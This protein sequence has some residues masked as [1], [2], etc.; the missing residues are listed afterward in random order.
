MITEWAVGSEV[1]VVLSPGFSDAPC[2]LDAPEPVF[3]QAFVSE[4]A[5]EA[6][7]G[8]VLHGLSGLDEVVPDPA[9]I[10]PLVEDP[11]GELRPVVGDD[12]LRSAPLVDDP[13]QHPPHP[14]TRQAGVH[15]GG[16]ALP[17]E[18]I[19]HVKSPQRPAIGQGGGSE[20]HGPLLTRSSGGLEILPGAPLQPFSDA[21]PHRQPFLLVEPVDPF[22]VH[23]EALPPQE[24]GAAGSRTASARQ[25]VPAGAGATRPSLSSGTDTDSCTAAFRAPDRPS[26]RSYETGSEGPPRPS[27]DPGASEFFCEQVPQPL[28]VEREFPHQLL[29]LSVLLLEP[30]QPLC[31]GHI[32]SAELGLPPVEGLL[33]HA[34][35]PADLY[36]RS[37]SLVLLQGQ[38]DL[39]L[40]KSALSQGVL[41]KERTHIIL[42]LVFRE[43]VMG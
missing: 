34:K 31:V 24:H 19:D 15:L 32:H 9:L 40:G 43:D 23:G 18:G 26:V 2:F 14:K 3:I 25:P 4:A 12:D 13:V 27:A 20:V 35:F 11:A 10:A 37:S 36:C 30:L 5:V 22:D 29:Q 21:L 42:G 38:D 7:A 39:L 1:I 16:Q 8:A 6:L 17:G 33:A 41:Q 28:I